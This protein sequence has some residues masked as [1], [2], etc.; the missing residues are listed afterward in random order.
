MAV[1]STRALAEAVWAIL[2]AAPNLDV[3]D[4]EVTPRPSEDTAGVVKGYAV[5]YPSPGNDQPASLAG[6][7][8]PVLWGF[9][10]T[11]VGGDRNYLLRTVDVVRG[12][13]TGRTL[14]VSGVNVGLMRPPLGFIPPT[15]EI[16]TV[17]PPRLE[18]PLQYQVL[19]TP[20]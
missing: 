20:A 17:K 2:D 5:F 3:Y 12:L 10:V 4:G 1:V 16:T 13:L 18:V 15:R 14:T 19:T 7:A 6:T 8:G 9:Q 11:C